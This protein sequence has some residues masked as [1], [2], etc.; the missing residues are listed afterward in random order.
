MHQAA[1]VPPRKVFHDDEAEPFELGMILEELERIAVADVLIIVTEE[2]EEESDVTLNDSDVLV[3]VK[4]Q[5]LWA[6]VSAVGSSFGHRGTMQFKRTGIADAPQV[7]YP[8][9]VGSLAESVELALRL[10]LFLEL[11][12]LVFS[13]IVLVVVLSSIVVLVA[14]PAA[15]LV[16][17]EDCPWTTSTKQR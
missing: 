13:G 2:L 15:I 8:L 16:V 14:L 11:A 4:V 9:R 5:K 1:L 12:L 6:R 17:V 7:E 3:D 10:S